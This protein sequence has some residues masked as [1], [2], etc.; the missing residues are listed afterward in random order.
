MLGFQTDQQII[1]IDKLKSIYVRNKDHFDKESPSI[2]VN[3][4]YYIN[5]HDMFLSE[6]MKNEKNFYIW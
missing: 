1:T 3:N 6:Q 4:K 2:L 5:P